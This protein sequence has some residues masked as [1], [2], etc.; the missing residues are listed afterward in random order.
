M[1]E[2]V[3]TH[4][5]VNSYKRIILLLAL[6]VTGLAQ[7]VNFSVNIR[8]S[9]LNAN[10]KVQKRCIYIVRRYHFCFILW[11]FRVQSQNTK[12]LCSETQQF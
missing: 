7:A 6:R 8:P 1:S 10:I 12:F 4:V 5:S 2:W 11:R 3:Y 9:V